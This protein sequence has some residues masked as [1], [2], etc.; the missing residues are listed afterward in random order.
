MKK[1][2]LI[3]VLFTASMVTF[4]S[5]GDDDKDNKPTD[6]CKTEQEQFNTAAKDF[7]VQ[8]DSTL[9]YYLPQLFEITGFQ[10]NYTNYLT[11]NPGDSLVGVVRVNNGVQTSPIRT[12]EEKALSAKGANSAIKT[13]EFEVIKNSKFAVLEECKAINEK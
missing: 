3:A 1:I 2:F 12:T 8:K 5:C 6:T 9:N 11:Q 13:Q 10:N 4:V 7:Q